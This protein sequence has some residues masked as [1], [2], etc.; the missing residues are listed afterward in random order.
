MSEKLVNPAHSLGRPG[1]HLPC[2]REVLA[3]IIGYSSNVR[4]DGDV[5]RSSLPALLCTCRG[6]QRAWLHL[7]IGQLRHTPDDV[8][9][10]EGRVGLG[11]LRIYLRFMR[12]NSVFNSVVLSNSALARASGMFPAQW[13]P[14]YETRADEFFFPAA[15]LEQLRDESVYAV[16]S[17][18]WEALGSSYW[19]TLALR[20]HNG[21]VVA[22][23]IA[24]RKRGQKY[25]VR[26][27]IMLLG[28]GAY[29]E[30]SGLDMSRGV[31]AGRAVR[32]SPQ[33]LDVAAAPAGPLRVPAIYVVGSANWVPCPGGV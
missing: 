11:A 5:Y 26:F 28:R 24:H 3:Q 18:I 2:V 33:V 17:H 19:L 12:E 22:N 32:L 6:F 8:A 23:F 31:A 20:K 1:I 29:V 25:R 9:T 27:N 13:T 16:S 4:L 30:L 7:G 14:L 15:R 10:L 21:R